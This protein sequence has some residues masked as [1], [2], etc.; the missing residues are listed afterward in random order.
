LNWTLAA[1]AAALALC[2]GASRVAAAEQSPTAAEL[3]A[4]E[5]VAALEAQAEALAV[6]VRAGQ[7]ELRPQLM[8]QLEYGAAFIGTAYLRGERDE[9]RSQALLNAARERQG[10]LSAQDLQARQAQCAGEA[11]RLLAESNAL[12]RAV[13]SQVA[14]RRMAKLLER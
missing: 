7:Q 9:P 6:Q 8:T 2:V 1:G 14:K 3:H 4:A 12:E 11:S 13:V 10:A 5:C